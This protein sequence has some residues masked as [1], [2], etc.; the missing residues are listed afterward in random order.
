M[1]NNSTF[2]FGFLNIK[3]ESTQNLI[4]ENTRLTPNFDDY[5]TKVIQDFL[6]RVYIS[7]YIYV[8]KD[9]LVRFRYLQS[10]HF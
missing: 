10:D 3:N 4:F 9:F 8:D 1:I 6:G 5:L 7:H 2:L